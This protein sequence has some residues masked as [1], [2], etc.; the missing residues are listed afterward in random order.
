MN[1]VYLLAFLLIP[2]S[3]GY[4]LEVRI[5]EFPTYEACAKAR[6]ALL[7]DNQMVYKMT[8]ECKEH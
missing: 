5:G 6:D 4:K 3:A 2:N 1:V 7:I 8:L